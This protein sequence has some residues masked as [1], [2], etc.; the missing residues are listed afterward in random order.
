MAQLEGMGFSTVH[1][2]KALLTS[3][4]TDVEN[5]MECLFVHLVDPASGELCYLVIILSLDI[6]EPI[7]VI[8]NLLS[9]LSVCQVLCLL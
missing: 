4:N 1:C 7:Q 8:L 2:Q 3:G 9:S 6:D 5:T